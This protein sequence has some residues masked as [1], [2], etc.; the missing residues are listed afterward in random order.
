MSDDQKQ[1]E[2]N[3]RLRRLKRQRSLQ[4]FRAQFRIYM[5][6]K[7]GK[8]GFYILLTFAII[9]LLSPL[10]APQPYSY[11]APGIDTHVA[12]ERAAI[13]LR[14]NN[15]SAGNNLTYF[16]PLA[17]SA[18]TTG[19]YVIYYAVSN[20]SLYSEGIGSTGTTPVNSSFYLYTV[21]VNSTNHLLSPIIFPLLNY[22][23]LIPG[24]QYELQNFILLSTTNGSL[25]VG[26]AGWTG[27][28]TG[29]GKPT[30]VAVSHASVN[31]TIVS[32]PV[33]DSI[34]LQFT[35]PPF[36]PF[37][38]IPSDYYTNPNY[39]IGNPGFVYVVSHNITGYY[40]NEFQAFPLVHRWTIK[41]NTDTAPRNVL[42]YGS[43]F[44][45]GLIADQSSV[46]V[47]YSNN[48]SAYSPINGRL[49]WNV[50]TNSSI[51][52]GPYI[53]RDYQLQSNTYNSLFIATADNNV[54]SVNIGTR[55]VTTILHSSSRVT[56]FSSSYGSVGFPAVLVSETSTSVYVTSS[57]FSTPH[58]GTNTTNVS[59]SNYT[60]RNFALPS[61]Y[62]SYLTNPVFDNFAFTFII[63]SSNGLL[64]SLQTGGG[65][66]PFTWRATLTPTPENI[67][68]PIT[69]YD[70]ATGRSVIG[71][72][73]STGIFYIYDT[74]AYD[75]N[76]IP[77]TFHTV[78]GAIF[79]LGTNQEGQDLFAQ[80]IQSFWTD[81][82][83]GVMIGI[84][85]IA[86][87]LLAAMVIG[88]KGGAVGSI[89]EVIS[90]SV[91]LIPGLALLISLQSVIG[92][93]FTNLV[94]IVTIVS[95]PF[96]T[97]TLIGIVR[98]IKSRTF[99]EAARVS[100]AGFFGIMRRHIL[101][102]I[103]PLTLYLL[104]L[105][106]SGGVAA[107]SGLQFLGLAPLNLST[108]GGML[109]SVL[110]NFYYAVLAPWWV[111]PPAIALTMFIFAFIF[112]SRGLDEVVNPRLRRR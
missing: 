59:R 62:G 81:W 106:I 24:G 36:V 55:N 104:S 80:F 15:T 20:G 60:T 22:Q 66:Y 45:L 41:L 52:Q 57:L 78:T 51:V 100:G 19:S 26:R 17:S 10:L 13:D 90:L 72:I 77:P 101:P 48:L 27:A 63:A 102:N 97:F 61:G 25:Y 67:S 50:H 69:F 75:L 7:Y 93:S 37:Y 99:V 38:N 85:T 43:F 47:S 76:P 32:P 94:W 23:A 87:A 33:S 18:S 96:T 112:A 65:L 89:F 71:V 86:V 68:Q 3:K 103:A 56:G 39:E 5:K 82:L 2:N 110:G 21:P 44:L 35:L 111:L 88:Y 1:K 8:A 6:S 11:I 4:H 73:A 83:L 91:Y 54:Y 16:G 9:A 49:V 53:P 105:A 109:N 14:V 107:V 46:I 40:L 95:W 79:P 29:S 74:N 12:K 28:Q 58:N 64:F 42:Y 70:V 84:A 92:S 98:Q 108:W 34:P 30:F 31:G